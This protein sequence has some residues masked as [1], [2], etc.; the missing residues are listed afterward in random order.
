MILHGKHSRSIAS[1][2]ESSHRPRPRRARRNLLSRRTSPV[3]ILP[4]WIPCVIPYSVTEA[5]L[6]SVGPLP[7]EVSAQAKLKFLPYRSA[8]DA[9]AE[10]FHSDVH[11][12]ERLNPGKTKTLKSGDQILVPNVEPFDLA[13]VKEIK[14]G[15][16]VAAQ[17]VNDV[18]EEPDAQTK[19][20]EENKETQKNE[21]APVPDRRKDRHEDQHARRVRRR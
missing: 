11:L 13:S 9:I 17:V 16:E 21:D 18:E 12:L 3:L 1:R 6:Q 8:A 7:S 10:K 20:A 4:V 19:N 15:S 5:D 2:V 14:P